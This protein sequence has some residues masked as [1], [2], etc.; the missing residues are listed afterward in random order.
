MEKNWGPSPAVVDA[1]A[2]VTGRQGAVLQILRQQDASGGGGL[3]VADV[4][5]AL[6]LHVNTAREHLDALVE[7][8]FATRQRAESTGRGRP[9]WIYRLAEP[10]TDER[11]GA[12]RSMA[13]VL[14][15]HL[16]QTAVDARADAREL[17]RKWGRELASDAEPHARGRVVADLRRVGFAPVAESEDS[18]ALTRCPLLDAAREYPEVTCQLHLGLIRGILGDDDQVGN[19]VLVP[20][21]RRGSCTLRLPS[22][23]QS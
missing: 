11:F 23:R 6:D 3:K 20:F 2:T 7:A 17:G 5:E 18:F 15:G 1:P 22:A 12:Y 10:D 8:G 4:A 9:A 13:M 19:P 21:A 14:A 16:S